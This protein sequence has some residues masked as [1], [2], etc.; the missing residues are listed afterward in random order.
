MALALA[1]DVGVDPILLQTWADMHLRLLHEALEIAEKKGHTPRLSQADLALA[2][3][4]FRGGLPAAF[5][6]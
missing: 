4:V 3:S 1:R 6:A 2:Q 5:S